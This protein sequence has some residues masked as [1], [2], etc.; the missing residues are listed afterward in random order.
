MIIN[1]LWILTSFA[2]RTFISAFPIAY[3]Y[4]CSLNSPYNNLLISSL[5]NELKKIFDTIILCV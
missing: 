1:A 2:N 4:V 5:I 3:I